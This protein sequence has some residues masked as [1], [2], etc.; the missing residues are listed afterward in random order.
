MNRHE[1]TAVLLGALVACGC[2]PPA[3]VSAPR[4]PTGKTAS[5]PAPPPPPPG[6]PAAETPSN[7]PHAALVAAFRAAHARK[8]AQ[9]ILSLYCFD[10]VSE[11]MRQTVRQNVE[12]ELR[13]PIKSVSVVPTAPGSHGPTVEGGVH[14]RPSLQVVALLT[15]TFDTSRAAPG[16]LVPQQL[17]LTVGKKGDVSYFTAPVRE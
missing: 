5:A 12:A 14:W 9:A 16:E 15:V 7:D 11:D 6:Q 10:G 8:D 1:L 4:A 2:E 13:Y 3:N 17:R